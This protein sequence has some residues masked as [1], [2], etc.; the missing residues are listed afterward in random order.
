M[1]AYVRA[2]FYFK[3]HDTVIAVGVTPSKLRKT[4]G[5]GGVVPN[6]LL[7]PARLVLKPDQCWLTPVRWT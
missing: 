6:E 5:R 4:P 3:K 2:C 7:L 1:S